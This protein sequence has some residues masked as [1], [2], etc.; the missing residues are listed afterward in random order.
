MKILF[1][2]F[3]VVA[4]AS[5][6]GAARFSHPSAVLVVA[7]V[8]CLDAVQLRRAACFDVSHSIAH[9]RGWAANITDA[10]FAKREFTMS[11]VRKNTLSNTL[12]VPITK[13]N[14]DL[15]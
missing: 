15:V 13:F 12:F 6:R 10:T 2:G 14:Q 3:L 11:T 8:A 7:G 5:A 9:N 1:S 4:D